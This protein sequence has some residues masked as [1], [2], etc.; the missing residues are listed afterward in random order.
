M[1][2]LLDGLD[3][4]QL[5]RRFGPVPAERAIHLVRQICHS[6]SEA[7]SC[8]LV[9]RDIKPANVFVCRYGEEYDFVKVLDFGIVRRRTKPLSPNR[10]SPPTSAFT[11]RRRSL[12]RNRRWAGRRST[13]EPTFTPPGAWPTGF[14]RGSTCSPPR[15]RWSWC[16]T[17]SKPP[18][19]PS[20][21]AELPT[22]AALDRLV[23]ACL[24]QDPNQ[25]PRSARELSR[26]LA[27]IHDVSAWTEERAREWWA[28]YQPGYSRLALERSH[29]SAPP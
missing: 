20:T 10:R 16:S 18:V 11:A 19:P 27:E 24:A 17:T 15:S 3:S 9:H 14:S 4:D 8:G 26:R 25:R 5:V 7:E 23:L 28:A 1:M 2:E 6:L 13:A 22:P 29:E 21:R 12:R